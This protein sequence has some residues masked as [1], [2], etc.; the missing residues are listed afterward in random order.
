M[1]L[2]SG[3]SKMSPRQNSLPPPNT[4]ACSGWDCLQQSQQFGV[5]FSII[6]SV[7]TFAFLYWFLFWRRRKPLT[8]KQ[9]GDNPEVIEIELRSPGS[10]QTT[11]LIRFAPGDLGGGR[12]DSQSETVFKFYKEIPQ[13]DNEPVRLSARSDGHYITEGL[14]VPDPSSSRPPEVKD[15]K[16]VQSSNNQ[17]PVTQTPGKKIQAHNQAIEQ[18]NA[19]DGRYDF[20][21]QRH[22]ISHHQRM[23]YMNQLGTYW[24]NQQLRIPPR[25]HAMPTAMPGVQL[26]Q[27]PMVHCYPYQPYLA[28]AYAPMPATTPAA[29]MMPSQPLQASNFSQ[30]SHRAQAVPIVQHVEPPFGAPT[31]TQAQPA[32]A[33]VPRT[34]ASGTHITAPTGQPPVYR[35]TPWWRRWVWRYPTTGRASTIDSE[36]HISRSHSTHSLS[37]RSSNRSRSPDQDRSAHRNSRDGGKDVRSTS[38]KRRGSPVDQRQEEHST[39]LSEKQTEKQPRPELSTDFNLSDLGSLP[40]HTTL[41]S[42]SSHGSQINGVSMDKI[43]ADFERAKL[44]ESKSPRTESL[45]PAEVSRSSSRGVIM[46]KHRHSVVEGP[47]NEP[48]GRRTVDRILITISPP[49]SST[50]SAKTSGG[51]SDPGDS[52]ELKSTTG[53]SAR[54]HPDAA[55]KRILRGGRR[56]DRNDTSEEG[57]KEQFLSPKETLL[58]QDVSPRTDGRPVLYRVDND[59]DGTASLCTSIQAMASS[60]GTPESATY[61]DNASPDSPR[62]RLANRDREVRNLEVIAGESHKDYPQDF[63]E[64]SDSASFRPRPPKPFRTEAMSDDEDQ[65]SEGGAGDELAFKNRNSSR[66]RRGRG[67]VDSMEVQISPPEAI[68]FC[69]E[70]P[71]SPSFRPGRKNRGGDSSEF[72]RFRGSDDN[73]E[74]Q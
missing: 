11:A 8:K 63:H 13:S 5:I 3:R 37:S 15:R 62:R 35:D 74:K 45:K 51:A 14:L 52:S 29:S 72:F 30:T 34:T 64:G 67:G 50:R 66:T 12:K 39:M 2:L 28:S 40:S 69:E 65:S 61:D 60:S 41:D 9:Q 73:V 36:S 17:G 27:V 1:A 25:L 31:T 55:S 71:Q 56:G 70:L 19:K 20:C 44:A 42:Y 57:T 33:A 10:S 32:K 23:M 53:K 22:K 18:I 49:I 48:T 54:L 43:L 58:R 26:G 16:R 38:R 47:Q 7:F 24:Y 21:D 46:E 68:E 6:L 4:T 59:G